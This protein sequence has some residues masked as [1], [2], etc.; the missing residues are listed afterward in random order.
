MAGGQSSF[1]L[2]DV[3]RRL[4]SYRADQR[5]E[6]KILVDARATE[7]LRKSDTLTAEQ[8]RLLDETLS[9]GK[10]LNDVRH[11]A[12]RLS[13]FRQPEWEHEQPVVARMLLA[14]QESA[15]DRRNWTVG[16]WAEYL[17]LQ[18][19]EVPSP[20][21][22]VKLF[23]YRRISYEFRFCRNDA[24]QAIRV[25]KNDEIE[26][27]YE[28]VVPIWQSAIHEVL[29]RATSDVD[30][31]LVKLGWYAVCDSVKQLEQPDAVSRF[32]AD[33]HEKGFTETLLSKLWAE[34]PVESE[35]IGLPRQL[36]TTQSG[37]AQS[38]SITEESA[39]KLPQEND[40]LMRHATAQERCPNETAVESPFGASRQK[41]TAN[42]GLKTTKRS[43]EPGEARIKLISALT[44]H[45]QYA[46][47]GCL[48]LV[49]VGNN[50]LARLAVVSR[51]SASDFFKDVFK[52]H[53][54]YKLLCCKDPNGL[55]RALKTLNG[56]FS[57][58][59]LYGG[60]PPD[61]DDRHDA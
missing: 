29:K 46:D 40:R 12:E 60:S 10:S 4:L 15:A 33:L 48:K 43:T 5:H 58:D 31:D 7:H 13:G 50:E 21:S 56:D 2:G 25:K 6:F 22:V 32:I 37:N 20:V 23:D 51:S 57:V 34:Y 16:K 27:P 42:L 11:D 47:G 36:K 8:K 3:L 55:G 18:T 53:R 41:T 38:M 19:S 26:G 1:H 45:H 14:L 9:N 61:E 54:N 35:A 24:R 30:V 28:P 52:G 17:N 44:L 49:H 59:D 39:R